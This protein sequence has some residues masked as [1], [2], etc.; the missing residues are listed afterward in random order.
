MEHGLR[1]AVEAC[2][3]KRVAPL[4]D[5]WQETLIWS[6]LEGTMGDVYTLPVSVPAAALCDCADFLYIAGE[7]TQAKALLKAWKAEHAG[8]YRILT[9]ANATLHALVGEVFGSDAQPAV[10]CAFAKGAEA[11]DRKTL[12]CYA[13]LLPEGVSLRLF[14]REMY[15]L[16]M[17]NEWSEDFCIEFRDAEDY[18]ARGL[19]VAALY[20][21]ELVGGAS[22][23][24]V[25]SSGIEIQVQTRADW[26][27]RGIAT[28]CSA[29]L[30]LE[31]LARG[32]Y[33]SWDA[34]NPIS[35]ALA[36]KLGYRG[37]KTYLTWDVYMQ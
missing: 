26:F 14:D 19:G 2:M 12:E 25:Y 29:R 17:A 10:R 36:E 8:E 32:L 3:R 22:S 37:A 6:A 1:K 4:F 15:E 24:T 16:A 11:F 5:G 31:C 23:Y 20:G 7:A 35:Q 34:A 18:L 9:A 21:G 33:P 30:I 28:A 13:A 27:H